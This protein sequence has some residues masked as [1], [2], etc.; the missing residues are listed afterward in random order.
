MKEIVNYLLFVGL[1]AL[2]VWLFLNYSAAF[3]SFLE[4]LVGSVAY[5]LAIVLLIFGPV[6]IGVLVRRAMR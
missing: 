6:L 4:P 5:G 2:G 1:V 3:G